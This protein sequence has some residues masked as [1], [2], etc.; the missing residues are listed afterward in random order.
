MWPLRIL[1]R[2]AAGSRHLRACHGLPLSA[3][4]AH[5]RDP[6]HPA[7]IVADFS[8]ASLLMQVI[9]PMQ[10]RMLSTFPY[11][12]TEGSDLH[13]STRSLHRPLPPEEAV[14]L[15]CCQPLAAP[16]HRSRHFAD[17]CALLPQCLQASFARP[18]PCSH[19]CQRPGF[20]SLLA[21]ANHF[22]F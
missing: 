12:V 18:E 13:L 5:L 10:H 6:N 22:N 3:Q 16:Q 7:E 8:I 17:M 11:S 9:T 19:A 1:A 21:E 4:Q 15:H 14:A 20:H 2:H